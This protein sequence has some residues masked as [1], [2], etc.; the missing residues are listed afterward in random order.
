MV[1]ISS[2]LSKKGVKYAHIYLQDTHTRC[3]KMNK[4]FLFKK[5]PDTPLT[6]KFNFCCYFICILI[7]MSLRGFTISF[8]ILNQ[9][10]IQV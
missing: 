5:V 3:L 4:Q 6:R 10:K 2:L 7:K 8:P 9:L 1:L